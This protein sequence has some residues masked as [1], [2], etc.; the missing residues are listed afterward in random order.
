MRRPCHTSDATR[1][2][3]VMSGSVQEEFARAMQGIV[4]DT[5]ARVRDEAPQ[6]YKDLAKVM[7]NQASLTEVVHRYVQPSPAHRFCI[8][9]NA[10]KVP[11]TC[12]PDCAAS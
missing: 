12:A 5:D 3:L 1:P 8:S 2:V 9:G 4:C 6:A 10:Q 7:A 11:V